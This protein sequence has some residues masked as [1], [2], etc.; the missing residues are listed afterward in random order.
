MKTLTNKIKEIWAKLPPR[1]QSAV[2]HFVI[3]FGVVFLAASKPLLPAVFAAL[4]QGDYS[5]AKSLIVALVLG[6]GAAAVRVVVPILVGYAKSLVDW[7]AVKY[8]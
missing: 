7:F 4:K 8:L 6:A 1:A 2:R 5:T 3:T